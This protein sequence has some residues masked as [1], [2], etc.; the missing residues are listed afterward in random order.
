MAQAHDNRGFP[1]QARPIPGNFS[2]RLKE[3]AK[4]RC[5]RKAKALGAREHLL[6]KQ[7][8]AREKSPALSLNFD[9][10]IVRNK[11]QAHNTCVN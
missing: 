4:A 6:W 1:G 9:Y 5:S 10:G 7:W 11:S 2:A 8:G 3:H